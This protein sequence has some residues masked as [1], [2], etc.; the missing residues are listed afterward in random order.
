M[1]TKGRNGKSGVQPSR[2]RPSMPT[3]AAKTS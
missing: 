2:A 3:F 1:A